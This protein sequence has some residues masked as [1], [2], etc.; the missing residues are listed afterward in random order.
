MTTKLAYTLEEAADQLS[1]TRSHLFKL[2]N[3]GLLKTYKTGK[4]RFASH[5]ALVECQK[6][7]EKA[8]NAGRAA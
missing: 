3:T 5:A 1:V 6:A 4:R 8:S 7:M 2:I